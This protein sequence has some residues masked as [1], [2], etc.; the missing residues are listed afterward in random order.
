[1]TRHKGIHENVLLAF[2][3]ACQLHFSTLNAMTM[4]GSQIMASVMKSK[5][6]E[7]SIYQAEQPYV[8]AASTAHVR[9]LP[10][11]RMRASI[12]L[13]H[14]TCFTML[15]IRRHSCALSKD[16]PAAP[17]SSLTKNIR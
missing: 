13:M 6:K 10:S 17:K 14:R 7:L 16:P 4:A 2:S 9:R 8:A 11:W 15:P 3:G 5:A 12:K 1:M